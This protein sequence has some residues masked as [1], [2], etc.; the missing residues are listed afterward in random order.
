MK[1]IKLLLIAVVFPVAGMYAQA[2]TDSLLLVVMNQQ[3][4]NHVV[5]Q[6]TTELLKLYADD[7]MFS[8]GSGIIDGRESW[9]KTVA[10]G[11]FLSR[12]HDSVTVE[13]H[14]D[15]AIVKGKLSVQKKNEDKTDRYHVKYIRVYA[16]R[17]KQWQMVSHMTTYEYHEQ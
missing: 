11:G 6:N 17:N 3:I 15:L 12:R 1:S 4:D 9:L 5:Q 8:H 13:M 16:Y 2:A 14:P 7:F 10:K